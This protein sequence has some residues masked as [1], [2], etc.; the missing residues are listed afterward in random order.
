MEAALKLSRKIRW[1]LPVQS[2]LSPSGVYIAYEEFFNTG[3][4]T[5]STRFGSES[6]KNRFGSRSRKLEIGYSLKR[7][8]L[9]YSIR[10]VF[11]EQSTSSIK[12]KIII[13][14][15]VLNRELV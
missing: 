11:G 7:S 2:E 9:K 15:F 5:S 8:P 12:K 14:L 6:E 3:T 1:E 13:K 4:P 10:E